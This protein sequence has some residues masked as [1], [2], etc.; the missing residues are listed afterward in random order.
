MWGGRCGCGHVESNSCTKL[1]IL[2]ARL[3]HLIYCLSNQLFSVIAVWSA[4][5]IGG[6]GDVGVVVRSCV[7]GEVCLCG[8]MCV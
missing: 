1:Y 8:E 5:Q 7:Y 3:Y 4:K 6:Y 2:R